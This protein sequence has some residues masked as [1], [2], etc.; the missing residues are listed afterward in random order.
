M[1]EC[2]KRWPIRR[3]IAAAGPLLSVQPRSLI[4]RKLEGFLEA[5]KSGSA[6]PSE[7]E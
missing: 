6:A 3:R 1:T 7:M 4:A 2:V 5:M